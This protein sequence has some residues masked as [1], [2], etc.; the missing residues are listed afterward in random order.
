MNVGSWSGREDVSGNVTSSLGSE[1]PF[2]TR[3]GNGHVILKLIL[4]R[5]RTVSLVNSLESATHAPLGIG[6]RVDQGPIVCIRPDVL[7][8]SILLNLCSYLEPIGPSDTPCS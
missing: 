7:Q 8:E 1:T 3:L 4:V 2:G 5:T 6:L